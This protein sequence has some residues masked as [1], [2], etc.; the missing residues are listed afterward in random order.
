MAIAEAPI[1]SPG[2]ERH[3]LLRALEDLGA[4]DSVVRSEHVPWPEDDH[5]EAADGVLV[6]ELV[7]RA[8]LVAHVGA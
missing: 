8:D 7:L 3:A 2:D 5:G 4:G 6:A 1:A